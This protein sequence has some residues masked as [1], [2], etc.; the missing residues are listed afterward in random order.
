MNEYAEPTEMA[1]ASQAETELAYAW[2]LDYD[3]PDEFPTERLTPR[4]ITSMGLAASLV[5]IAVAGV[6]AVVMMR[7]PTSDFPSAPSAPSAPVA[8]VGPWVPGTPSAP[9]APVA[10]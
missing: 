9:V 7:A 6:V 10:P 4:R 2:A 5:T 1:G 3:D 8:P